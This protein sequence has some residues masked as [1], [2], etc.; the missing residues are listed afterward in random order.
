MLPECDYEAY[1]Q[2][3]LHWVTRFPNTT[4]I[5]CSVKLSPSKHI[6]LNMYTYCFMHTFTYHTTHVHITYSSLISCTYKC[7][8]Y[9]QIVTTYRSHIVYI[10][11][12]RL[13]SYSV[14]NT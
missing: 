2:N 3:I 5:M 9:A 7:S 14:I 10:K 8:H 4:N 1:V 11:S 12:A 6:H 13:I